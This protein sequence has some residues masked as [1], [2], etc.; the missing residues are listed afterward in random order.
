MTGKGQS[1]LHEAIEG[2]NH[3]GRLGLIVYT[4][5][6]FPTPAAYADVL[7][8][9]DRRREVSILETTIPASG[10]YSDHANET[11]VRAHRIACD[12]AAGLGRQPKTSTPQLSVLYRQTVEELGLPGVIDRLAG[13]VSGV[14]LEWDERDQSE[15]YR[16]AFASA[17]IELVECV[18]PWHSREDIQRTLEPVGQRPLV[19]LMSAERTGGKLFHRRRLQRCVDTIRQERPQARIAAG[20]GIRSPDDVR[21]VGRVS[22]IDAVIIGTAFL[23]ALERSVQQGLDFIEQLGDSCDVARVLEGMS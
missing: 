1:K 4:V 15:T 7:G 6:G 2:A 17:D 8:R 21:A 18:G 22:G 23:S 12:N 3:E 16:A 14:L 13:V 11:I 5:S 20:F 10:G 9:L 19:Y